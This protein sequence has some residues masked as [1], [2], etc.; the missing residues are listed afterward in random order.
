MENMAKNVSLLL[1]PVTLVPGE[2][3]EVGILYVQSCIQTYTVPL[4]SAAHRCRRDAGQGHKKGA[5][6]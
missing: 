3:F 5:T 4:S 2:R 1:P 6:F